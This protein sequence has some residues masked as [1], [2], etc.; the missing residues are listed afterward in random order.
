MQALWEMMKSPRGDGDFWQAAAY[1]AANRELLDPR[2]LGVDEYMNYRPGLGQD[3]ETARERGQELLAHAYRRNAALLYNEPQDVWQPGQRDDDGLLIFDRIHRTLHASE[4]HVSAYN[5]HAAKE[6][7]DLH[8]TGSPEERRD[9]LHH[10]TGGPENPEGI[11]AYAA[12]RTEDAASLLNHPQRESLQDR[13]D[14]AGLLYH[15]GVLAEVQTRQ[16]NQDLHFQIN[17]LANPEAAEEIA[18]P[19]G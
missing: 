5:E 13:D 8:W 17:I 6:G 11:T 19:P 14:A 1:G 10:L 18:T 12:A 15:A 3:T 4:E 9:A 16:L 7:G 2:S